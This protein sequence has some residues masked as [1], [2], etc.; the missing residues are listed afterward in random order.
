VDC[1]FFSPL[2]SRRRVR[3][4]SKDKSFSVKTLKIKV[5]DTVAFRNDDSFFHNIYSLSDVQT[6]DLGLSPRDNCGRSPLPSRK[7]RGRVR[8]PSFDEAGDRGNEV[9]RVQSG[10]KTWTIAIVDRSTAARLC[11]AIAALLGAVAL[12]GWGQHNPD[13]VRFRRGLAGDGAEYGVV[14][15]PGRN[16][17][18]LAGWQQRASRRVRLACGWYCSSSLR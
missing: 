16:G 13:L 7:S 6:F 4:R 17:A 15:D 11:G 10:V 1:F 9:G 14:R 8:D 18:R 2:P 3:G 12:V 5:G